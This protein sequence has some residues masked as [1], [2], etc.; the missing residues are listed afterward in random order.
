VT[1]TTAGGNGFLGTPPGNNVFS[2]TVVGV[3]FPVTGTIAGAS[4]PKWSPP[5]A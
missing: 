4:G 2:A 5:R 1:F 3:N